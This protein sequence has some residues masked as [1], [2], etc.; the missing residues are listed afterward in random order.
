MGLK[1]IWRPRGWVKQD[2][3]VSRTFLDLNSDRN[4]RA[5]QEITV[6]YSFVYFLTPTADSLKTLVL[7]ELKVRFFL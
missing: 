4:Q 1:C 3:E 2:S 5:Q 6:L 7:L